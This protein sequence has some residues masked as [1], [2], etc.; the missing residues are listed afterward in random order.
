MIRFE[1]TIEEA[2]RG[3]ALIEIP[4]EVVEGLGG[5][6]EAKKPETGAERT[7]ERLLS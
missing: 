2:P 7:V 3:G 4:P 1:T 5:V 6:S